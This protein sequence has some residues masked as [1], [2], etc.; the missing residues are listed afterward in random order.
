MSIGPSPMCLSC[1]HFDA[2]TPTEVGGQPKC[3][4]FPAGIP[5]S[6]YWD[7]RI[8]HRQPWPGDGGIRFEQ[9]P[10]LALFD[11]DLFEEVRGPPPVGSGPR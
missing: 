5:S 4:A 2:G 1:R 10:E 6:I 8:D 9:G 3:V 11:F 7:G